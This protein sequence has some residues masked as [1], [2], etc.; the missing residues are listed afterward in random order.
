MQLRGYL[1]D[2]GLLFDLQAY[3]I[4]FIFG[5]KLTYFLLCHYSEYVDH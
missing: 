4:C 5:F 3:E 2:D 1:H